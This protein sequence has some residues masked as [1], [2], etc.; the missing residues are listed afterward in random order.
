MVHCSDFHHWRLSSRCEGRHDLVARVYLLCSDG[1]VVCCICAGVSCAHR[2]RR[3][4]LL[5]ARSV[6]YAA[7]TR[8][9]RHIRW[10]HSLGPGPVY[11]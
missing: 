6:T 3:P 4:L 9:I 1:L 5:R 2:L 7:A 8:H 10:C 11:V